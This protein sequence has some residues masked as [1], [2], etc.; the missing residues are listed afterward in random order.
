MSRGRYKFEFANRPAV[1]FQS[2]TPALLN[3][4]DLLVIDERSLNRPERGRTTN[5]AGFDQQRAR[6]YPSAGSGNNQTK[7]S[8][9]SIYLHP[10]KRYNAGFARTRRKSSIAGYVDPKQ[11]NRTRCSRLLTDAWLAAMF[12]PVPARSVTSCSAKRTSRVCKAKP[13]L[14]SALWVPLFER[15]ARTQKNDFKVKITSPFPHYENEPITFDIISSGKEPK[16]AIDNIDFPLTEDVYIDDLWHGTT[17]LEGNSW[18]D[19]VIDSATTS[20]HVSKAG[21]WPAVRA[22]NNRKATALQAGQSNNDNNS[23]AVKDDRQLKIILFS[24]FIARCRISLAG[25]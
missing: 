19:L 6:R 17:W 23:I 1:N 3:E 9:H 15:C 14:H 25:S 18:H 13:K 22:N 7:V 4:T 21:D 10:T 24:I 16:L 11:N 8:S 2:L 5:R 20:I 12:I